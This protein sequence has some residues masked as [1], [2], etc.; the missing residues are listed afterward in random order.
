M[1]KAIWNICYSTEYLMPKV[2]V[3]EVGF[4]FG[5]FR[6][7]F[8]T[9]NALTHAMIRRSAVEG[10][11]GAIIGLSRSD[12][13]KELQA[14]KIAIEIM[15]PVRKLNMN[16]MHTNPD[17]WKGISVYLMNKPRRKKNP[18]QFA[19]PA[20]VEFLI[21]PRYRIYVDSTTIHSGL[22]HSLR[23]KQT[24]F[25]PY[26]GTSSMISFLK[27]VDEYNYALVS[28]NDYVRITSVIRF[29]DK[30]PEVKVEK[31]L[32][33]AIEEG[34]PIHLDSHRTPQGLYNALYTPETESIMVI[35]N[36]LAELHDTD[37]NNIYVK[38]L[39]FSF[40]VFLFI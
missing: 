1:V 35:D 36:G 22:M 18:T 29:S 3:F 38:F 17:W 15:T 24:V 13:P 16:Y 12:Y 28:P 31:G 2:L 5:Y 39:F 10:L 20:S 7:A 30:I 27:Y 23:E 25:T 11:I 33:F 26:L 37:G 32:R 4:S 40:S 8:T 34:L 14:S 9:T 6:K 19:V 21:N